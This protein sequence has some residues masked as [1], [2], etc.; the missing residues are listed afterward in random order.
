MR[1]IIANISL[2]LDGVM[3]APGRPDEDTRGGFLHGGWA[4]P[5]NDAVMMKE[6]TAGMKKGAGGAMLFGRRTYQ[7]FYSV[8]PGRKDK[9]FSAALDAADKYVVSRTLKGKLPWKNSTL[10]G[11]EAV[12]T[13]TELKQGKGKDIVVLGSGVLLQSL[14]RAGLVDT[15]VLLIHPLV[16]GGGRRLFTDDKHEFALKLAKSVTTPKGVTIATYEKE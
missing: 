6:M 3:Q 12:S 9:P 11:G 7:D 15:L 16:L 5:Y 14:M 2:T 1:K 4:L 13:V 10:L 8:W